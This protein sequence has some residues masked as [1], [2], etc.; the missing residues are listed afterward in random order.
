M[1]RKQKKVLCRIIA[2]AV[3]LVAAFLA[4]RFLIK[5][6][7]LIATLAVYLVPYFIIG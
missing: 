3:L 2:S 1:S 7:S 6:Q 5:G 4:D